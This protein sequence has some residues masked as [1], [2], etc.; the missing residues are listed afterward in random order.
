MTDDYEF[1]Q[2]EI[3]TFRRLVDMGRS[4]HFVSWTCPKCGSLQRHPVAARLH[5]KCYCGESMPHGTSGRVPS[6]ERIEISE[7]TNAVA[8]RLVEL[9]LGEAR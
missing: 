3:D 6:C 7:E 2:D 9:A 8:R 5:P 1:W 4:S